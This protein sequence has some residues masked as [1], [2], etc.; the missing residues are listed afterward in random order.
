MIRSFEPASAVKSADVRPDM[1]VLRA[2]GLGT[3]LRAAGVFVSA[4]FLF[5][6]ALICV[7]SVS[8]P[9]ATY[10]VN[11]SGAPV[12]HDA[13]TAG[14]QTNPFCTPDYGSTRIAAGDTLYVQ[15]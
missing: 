9:A 12:C 6:L 13:T 3:V 4:S 2:G 11:N 8:A 10:Y 1:E 7:G 14:T 5:L 15:A